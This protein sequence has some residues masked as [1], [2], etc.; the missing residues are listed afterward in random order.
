MEKFASQ[1]YDLII[2]DINAVG[3]SGYFID[4]VRSDRGKQ[5]LKKY[6]FNPD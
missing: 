2:V 3:P 4:F 5:V 1:K 6:N